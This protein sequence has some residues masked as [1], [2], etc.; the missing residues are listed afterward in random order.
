MREE[1]SAAQWPPGALMVTT[2]IKGTQ[3]LGFMKWRVGGKVDSK[4]CWDNSQQ[5]IFL[6]NMELLPEMLADQN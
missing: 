1:V 5:A 6:L 2:S 3:Q 4:M